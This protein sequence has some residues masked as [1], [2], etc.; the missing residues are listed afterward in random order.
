MA[1]RALV[2]GAVLGGMG[3]AGLVEG[4]RLIRERD[5]VTVP[6]IIGP[7]IYV[8]L[9]AVALLATGLVYVWA[10]AK[11]SAGGAAGWSRPR[12]D[13]KLA[14]TFLITAGYVY[15]I[16]VLGYFVSSLL[17]LLAAFR[18][19]GVANWRTTVLLSAGIA[20]AYYILFVRYCEVIFPKGALF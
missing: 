6:E 19:A 12:I 13:R 16:G 3:V 4:V 8:L 2:E 10:N 1:R 17:F 5:A 7:D 18:C 11:P 14:L 9:L 15:A 20:S